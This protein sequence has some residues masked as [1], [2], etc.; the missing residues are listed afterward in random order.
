MP[1]NFSFSNWS[2]KKNVNFLLHSLQVMDE[3]IESKLSAEIRK[4]QQ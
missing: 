4:D 2:K 1:T 3:I